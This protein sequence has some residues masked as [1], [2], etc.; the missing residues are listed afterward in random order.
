MN[1]KQ[2]VEELN[3]LDPK[4]TVR[5]E[6]SRIYLEQELEGLEYSIEYN[7]NLSLIRLQLITVKDIADHIYSEWLRSLP[8]VFDS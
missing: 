3:K 1:I 8:E 2:I 6:K 7:V 5:C 4:I